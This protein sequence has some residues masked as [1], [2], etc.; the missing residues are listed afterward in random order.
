MVV[1]AR[2]LGGP[3][4][5]VLDLPSGTVLANF[6]AYDSAL[7]GGVY[8]AAGDVNND[9]R[10]E[11]VTGSGPDGGPQVNI[12][13]NNSIELVGSFMA[14][15]ED[16]RQGVRVGIG[17]SAR[18]GTRHIRTAPGGEPANE[19]NQEFDLGEMGIFVG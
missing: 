12:Y 11:L 1:G 8:V 18:D 15:D 7:R 19:F 16:D 10:A 17:E 9:G 4:V 6:F 14:G 2:E 13:G 5:T 3:R